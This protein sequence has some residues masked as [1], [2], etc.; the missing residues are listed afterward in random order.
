[1]NP[2]SLEERKLRSLALKW[3][4]LVGLPWRLVV[5]Y[6]IALPPEAGNR[7]LGEQLR[8]HV[9]PDLKAGCPCVMCGGGPRKF[10][11]MYGQELTKHSCEVANPSPA[12]S[13]SHTWTD[14]LSSFA[15]E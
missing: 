2:L 14:S 4:N 10:F 6:I 9:N 11:G 3:E 5:R 13:D 1:L 12:P 8:F 7:A 15:A